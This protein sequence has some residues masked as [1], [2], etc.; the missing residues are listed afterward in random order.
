MEVSL[1]S[2]HE[3]DVFMIRKQSER[4]SPGT[5]EKEVLCW[6]RKKEPRCGTVT[7]QPFQKEPGE[8]R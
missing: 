7:G 5:L 2:D 4:S 8:V 1:H 6:D 3:N